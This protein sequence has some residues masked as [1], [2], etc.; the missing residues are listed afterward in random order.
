MI[1]H[2]VAKSLLQRVFRSVYLVGHTATHP[3]GLLVAALL[4][5]GKGAALSH[6]TAA[7]LW[8]IRKGLDGVVDVTIAGSR[9]SRKG[10][11]YHRAQLRPDEIDW[12]DGLPVTTAARTVVDLATLLPRDQT[13]KLVDQALIEAV[14]TWEE[15][16]DAAA[17]QHR[18]GVANV[19]R[20]L[21]TKPDPGR[22]RSRKERW[23]LRVIRTAGLP[24]PVMNRNAEGYLLDAHWP[25]HKVAAEFDSAKYHTAPGRFVNDRR[26]WND[27]R[28]TGWA[29]V[30]LTEDDSVDEA[31][32]RLRK[33]FA[34]TCP[35]TT[36]GTPVLVE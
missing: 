24:E 21:G 33:A 25:E 17:G 32:E 19:R 36:P 8:A 9:K 1:D 35:S 22:P 12:I 3:H 4:A 20:A 18:R 34:Q 26:K 29:L 31:A 15:I 28:E 16:A 14:A 6:F 13:A 27:L 7:K 30:L 5:A 23:L 2:R 11:R 10:L